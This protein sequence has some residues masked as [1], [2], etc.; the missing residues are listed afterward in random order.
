[1]EECS[2]PVV[3]AAESQGVLELYSNY[4]LKKRCLS[5]NIGVGIMRK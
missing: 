2:F 5:C 3:N 4:C 1:M